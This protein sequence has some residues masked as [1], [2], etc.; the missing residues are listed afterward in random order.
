MAINTQKLLS[1][2]KLSPAERMAAAYD[3][4]IDDLLNIKIKKKLINVDKVFNKTKKVKEKTR[5]EKKTREEN[6]ARKKRENRLEQKQ[7]QGATKLSLPNLPRTG[8]LDSVQNFIGYTFLGYLM[9]TYYDKLPALMGVA[10]IL[11][12]ALETFGTVIRTTF[13]IGTSLI[14]GGYK[15][16]EDLSQKT[17]ELGGENAQKTFD[18]ASDS[19]KNVV[20][21]ILT[22]GLYQAPKKEKEPIPQKN[23][24]GYVKKMAPGGNVTRA[25]K[26][27]GGAVSRQIQKVE[28]RKI[29]VLYRQQ[30][31]PGKDIGGIKKIQTIFPSSPK[32]DE[33]GP[34]NTLMNTSSELSSVPFVGPLMSA[35][36]GIALGQKPDRRIYATFGESLA[37]MLKPSIDAQSNAS[38]NSIV[39]T[40]ASMAEGGAITRGITKKR[41]NTEELG[42]SLARI[43]QNSVESRLSRIFSQILKTK[44]AD[45]TPSDLLSEG[46][47]TVES[48]S[49][50]FWL[51][52]VASLLE[53]S[54]PQGA[55]D[56]AQA[57][58]NRVGS[59][60][61]P[62]SIRSVIMQGNGGQ[63]QP[64]RD[65][66]TISAW[67]S[68]K[69]KESA[70]DFIKKYGKGRTQ[71]Q[72]ERVAAALLD[73]SRQR[74][75]STFVGPRD[76]FR[77]ISF[78]NQNNHLADETEQRRHGHAFGFEPGGA[79]IGAFK[80]G[81][82]SP[83]QVSPSTTG[84]IIS[85]SAPLTGENGR[86]KPSQLT[87]VGTLHGTVSYNDWYG[88]GAYLRHE[89]ARAFLAA[90]AQAQKEGVTILITSA[91]RS[92]EHQA[93]VARDPNSYTP[94][95]PGRS[96]HGEGIALDI[97]TGTRGYNWFVRNGPT[98]GWNYMALPGDPVHFQYTGGYKPKTQV[99]TNKKNAPNLDP[100][101]SKPPELNMAS[102][103]PRVSNTAQQL[104]MSP[105]YDSGKEVV[106]VLSEKIVM[107][108]QN[109]PINFPSKPQS[110]QNL[111]LNS[112][113]PTSVG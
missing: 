9:T 28:S 15:F 90:K 46:P 21:S 61:W 111:G 38:I 34:L 59:P 23:T 13:N 62:N 60:A 72:L 22:L 102:V 108:D 91:Y 80:A 107:M 64:V 43:F 104:A 97:Q 45:L 110:I 99:K 68:I 26:P 113:V 33:P 92:L 78:E 101:S 6:E 88:N 3:K 25:G 31:Q 1:P 50:D 81:K 11:P 58:Y 94:A 16:R 70:V 112:R 53:N 85:S 18:E 100:I 41:T 95:A 93:A 74:S 87:K 24:G 79:Q 54:D 57:I 19:L 49:S 56:V 12:P 83:A 73:P 35:A 48:S 75:A 7:P 66:G 17:K 55:A 76:S 29:P 89:P 77:A 52:A 10:K 98:Y 105:S 14:E 44:T 42:F 36:I 5:K 32:R 109:S 82:L 71:S 84:T 4:K 96:P 65:Y 63:F 40:I 106:F 67:N 47:V 20:N 86:L 37:Y 30:I 69:D 103:N 2:G 51:L 39:S 8:F 27:T